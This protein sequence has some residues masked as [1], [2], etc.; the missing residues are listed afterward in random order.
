MS[1]EPGW[2]RSVH[3]DAAFGP[4]PLGEMLSWA[5]AVGCD[6]IE[7]SVGLQAHLAIDTSQSAC[8]ALAEQIRSAGLL[9]SALV[10]DGPSAGSL[11]CSQGEARQRAM[12][13]TVVALDLAACLGTDVVILP[14]GAAGAGLHGRSSQDSPPASTSYEDTYALALDALLSLRFEAERRAVHLACQ[15]NPRRFLLSLIETR[16]FIDRVNSPWV[17]LC[18]D[19][20]GALAWGDPLDWIAGLGHRIIRVGFGPLALGVRGAG[21]ESAPTSETSV[22]WPRIRSALRGIRYDAP[23]T[24]HGRID[25]VGG[26]KGRFDRVFGL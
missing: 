18:F 2:K 5:R 17:R 15:N 11:L 4:A 12:E 8:T 14:I 6:Q 13:Q 16:D 7:L 25:E 1:P 20:D 26:F 23:L 10:L 22:D 24:Y 9:V 21:H 3:V 19:L